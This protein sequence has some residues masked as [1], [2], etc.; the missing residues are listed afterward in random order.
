MK[1]ETRTEYEVYQQILRVFKLVW[2]AEMPKDAAHTIKNVFYFLSLTCVVPEK[3]WSCSCWNVC[4]VIYLHVYPKSNK[5]E[6]QFKNWFNCNMQ[7]TSFN[8]SSSFNKP[9]F[10]CKQTLILSEIFFTHCYD[11]WS[12]PFI[13]YLNFSTPI[14]NKNCYTQALNS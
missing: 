3:W 9:W 8:I 7:I 13:K 1:K 12:N 10:N 11:S 2:P 4:C 5:D 14:L 6:S